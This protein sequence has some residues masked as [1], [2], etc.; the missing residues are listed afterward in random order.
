MYTHKY[1][2]P[3]HSWFILLSD[4][5]NNIIQRIMLLVHRLSWYKFHSCTRFLDMY[6]YSACSSKQLYK[7]CV[8]FVPLHLSVRVSLTH[9]ISI[10]TC[11]GQLYTSF[12]IMGVL[13]IYIYFLYVWYI[14]AFWP[15]LKVRIVFYFAHVN[16]VR[17][18]YHTNKRIHNLFNR[19]PDCKVCLL[20]T[21][22]S[23]FV[24]G[25]NPGVIKWLISRLSMIVWVNVVLNVDSDW[26]FNNLCSIHLLSDSEDEYCRLLKC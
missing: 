18:G 8:Q 4:N 22:C 23:Y 26:C 16:E 17:N 24:K 14:Q 15:R 3:H 21:Y 9:L 6:I 7:K 25:L 2:R 19:P 1:L 13:L 11:M 20:S 10:H 12:T 5:N